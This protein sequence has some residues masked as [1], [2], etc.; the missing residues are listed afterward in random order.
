MNKEQDFQGLDSAERQAAL[1]AWWDDLN[2]E[3]THDILDE[4]GENIANAR[5]RV[6]P[7]TGQY[8]YVD[9]VDGFDLIDEDDVA[10]L[11]R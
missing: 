3:P 7:T 5:L 4:D 8:L 6:D 1:S 11:L 9:D 2:A 10:R